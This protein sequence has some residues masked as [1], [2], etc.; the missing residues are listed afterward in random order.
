MEYQKHEYVEYSKQRCIEN[1]KCENKEQK[2]DL[3]KE[4]ISNQ[5]NKIKEKTIDFDENADK[6]ENMGEE[7]DYFKKKFDIKEKKSGD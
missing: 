6:I 1:R 2:K 3:I 4:Q 7:Y 5:Y